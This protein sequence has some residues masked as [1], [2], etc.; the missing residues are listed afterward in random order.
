MVLPNSLPRAASRPPG[1]IPGDE[2]YHRLVLRRPTYTQPVTRLFDQF[3][4]ALGQAS[5]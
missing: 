4:H 1:I 5:A 3:A 2:R